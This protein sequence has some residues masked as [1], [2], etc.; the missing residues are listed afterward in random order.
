MSLEAVKGGGEY[1]SRDGGWGREQV[2]VVKERL[3]K[4]HLCWGE[5][6]DFYFRTF[7]FLTLHHRVLSQINFVPQQGC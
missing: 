7:F 2:G 3:T 4:K 5:K 1:W 6:Y